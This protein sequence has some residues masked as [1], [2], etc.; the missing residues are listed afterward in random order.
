MLE[1]TE[2]ASVRATVCVGLSKLLLSGVLT[3]E[4]VR[5]LFLPLDR[6]INPPIGSHQSTCALCL[7]GDNRQSRTATMPLLL[8]PRLQL[9][10]AYQ[11]TTDAKG[12][13]LDC[14]FSDSLTV[15]TDIPSRTS[16]LLCRA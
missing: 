2:S 11:S 8:L 4:R 9:Y 15:A 7:T 14:F 10:L 6:R 16:E 1:V 12:F 3:D 13:T 5:L